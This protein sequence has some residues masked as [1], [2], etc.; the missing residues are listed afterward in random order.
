LASKT[1][2]WWISDFVLKIGYYKKRPLTS[3]EV[4]KLTEECSAAVLNK[5]LENKK[6]LGCL[7]IECTIG[8]QHFNHALC[9]LGA[10]VSVMPTVVYY[11]L[12]HTVF[13][14]TT[15]CLQ[16]ADQSVRYLLGIAENILV[17][18]RDFFMPVDFVVL[19]MH[20]DSR[21]SLILG[22]PFWSIAN[23]YIDVRKGSI[24]FTINDQEEQFTFK[25]K[26]ELNSSMKMVDQDKQ[27]ESPESST[28]GSSVE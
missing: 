14:P 28:L 21:M 22:R 7:T 10:I 6:D 20:P 15:M 12:N 4:I 19:D 1:H 18:I 16:L 13:E 5:L 2:I 9:D 24:K 11:K 3:T 26:Q 23:A 25:S 8:D 27:E 17:Q